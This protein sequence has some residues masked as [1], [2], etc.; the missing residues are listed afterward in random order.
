[1]VGSLSSGSSGPEAGH[2]V[3]D[4]GDEVVELLRV[5]RQPLGQRCIGRPAAGSARRISSFGQLLE[6]REV[7]L[8]DQPAVQADLGVEQLV[9]QR[10]DRRR[11][12]RLGSSFGS[13]GTIC[14]LGASTG[15]KLGRCGA[16]AAAAACASAMRR[17]AVKR[18]NMVLQRTS[19]SLRS[20]DAGAGVAAPFGFFGGTISLLER[21]GD[22]VAGL[23]LVERHAAVDRLAHQAVIVRDRAGERVA[24]RLLDVGAA[25]AGP[26][27]PLLEAVDD[28]L[29]AAARRPAARG[30]RRPAGARACRPGTVISLTRNSRLEPSST[31]SVQE[32]Q[33]RGT[34]ITT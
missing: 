27:Q 20:L 3:E 15:G 29:R 2:L 9:A 18:P 16:A 24:E 31:L 10:R 1:M 14:R 13:S 4:L 32:N 33:V 28:D 11:G 6:R 34:S 19:A 21:A 26:E 5:E 30:S 22:V 25:Q 17:V 23:D 12:L 7:D 8:L